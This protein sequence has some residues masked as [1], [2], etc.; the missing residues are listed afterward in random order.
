MTVVTNTNGQYTVK[1]G[2]TLNQIASSQGRSLSSLLANNPQFQGNPNMIQP[3]QTVS[4]GSLTPQKNLAPAP[5]PVITNTNTQTSNQTGNNTGNV[6]Y[7]NLT[8]TN[9][10]NTSNQNSNTSFTDAL[11]KILKDAQDSQQQ[12]QKGLMLQKQGITGTGLNL[13][14]NSDYSMVNPNAIAG[15]RQGAINAVNPGELSVENQIKLSN[16]GFANVNDLVDKTLSGYNNAQDNARQ[17]DQLNETIRHNKADEANSANKTSSTFDT[18]ANTAATSAKMQSLTG[19][20]KGDPNGDNYIAPEDWI[21]MR[22]LWQSHGGSDS[23]F[24][25]NFKHYLNPESYDMAGLGTGAGA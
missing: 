24:V 17:Q 2:D 6:N 11:M 7:S 12:G 25:S 23:S 5:A 16:A 14:N 10:Q 13:A 20:A 18:S 4:Y 19:K 21:A 15:L 8:N 3:G 9:T 1:P 22:N